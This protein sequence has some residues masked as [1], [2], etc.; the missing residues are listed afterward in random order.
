MRVIIRCVVDE[1]RRLMPLSVV[2]LSRCKVSV[3]VAEELKDAA[4]H[5]TS[6]VQEDEKEERRVY[7]FVC[8]VYKLP[9]FPPPWAS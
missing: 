6:V 7:V 9:Y 5:Q 2:S 1:G 8:I 4:Q 3:W